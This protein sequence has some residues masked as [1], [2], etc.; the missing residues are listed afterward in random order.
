M[1]KDKLEKQLTE[2]DVEILSDLKEELAEEMSKPADERDEKLI[3]ELEEMISQTEEKIIGASKKRSLESVMKM[4]DEHKKP[5]HIKL[6]KRL[7]VAAAALVVALGVN[8]V[9]MKTLGQN[10]FS[11]AYQIVNGG[12]SISV[13][14]SGKNN[15][16]TGSESDPYGMKA[17]C[18]EYGFFPKTPSYIP[19][20]FVLN[21]IYENSDDVFDTVYFYFKKN[22]IKLNFFYTN[23]KTNDEIQPIGIPTDTYN[24]TE[25]KINGRTTYILMEDDQFT[26]IFIDN[27]IEHGIFAEGLDYDECYKVLES[28]S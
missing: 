7:S 15:G 9:S 10:M 21:D 19:D 26:S 27:R 23:Y 14:Q 6:Y 13:K 18:A 11:T 3:S 16:I 1:N 28:L 22:D 2:I 25:E 12:I 17:K 24:I 4:L 5:K 20:G 8:A